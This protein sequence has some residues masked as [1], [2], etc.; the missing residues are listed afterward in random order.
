MGFVAG[1]VVFTVVGLVVLSF[2]PKLRLTRSNL[3]VFVVGAFPV[4]AVFGYLHEL[5]FADAEHEL[6]SA[7][8]VLGFFM[9]MLVGAILGGT[10][11][12][13]IKVRLP[14]RTG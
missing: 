14:K 1:C 8:A 4:A 10:T 2:L 12:V 3:F 7:A 9:A 11:L 13:W 5:V 6:H